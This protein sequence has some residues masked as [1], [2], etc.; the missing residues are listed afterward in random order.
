[1]SVGTS[2]N[3]GDHTIPFTLEGSYSLLG[4]FGAKPLEI[5][6]ALVHDLAEVGAR[7][8]TPGLSGVAF[9]A[10]RIN[11]AQDKKCL[12]SILR[13]HRVRRRV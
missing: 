13:A 7:E 4:L 6:S 11:S 3:M 8:A 1:M 10:P 2:T 5:L 12:M 9:A